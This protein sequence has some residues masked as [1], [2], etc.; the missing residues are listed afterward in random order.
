[1]PHNPNLQAQLPVNWGKG[2]LSW[3]GPLREPAAAST[4]V[5]MKMMTLSGQQLNPVRGR[6]QVRPLISSIQ[7][8]TTHPKT[9]LWRAQPLR[10]QKEDRPGGELL[11]L[12][13]QFTMNKKSTKEETYKDWQANSMNLQDKM[14]N[15]AT[16][17]KQQE[18]LGNSS[19]RITA[20]SQDTRY[21]MKWV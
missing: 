17:M 11:L 15:S 9:R 2:S 20:A 18:Q 5:V 8:H 13:D 16:P 19:F 14:Q 3:R 4:M 6:R 7:H 1:M 21:L 12:A 10:S